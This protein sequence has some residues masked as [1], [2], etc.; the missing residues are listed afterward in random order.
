MNPDYQLLSDRVA[1]ESRVLANTAYER[2]QA[3]LQLEFRGG[4]VYQYFQVPQQI[5]QGLLQADSKGLYF[6]RHIRNAFRCLRIAT[7]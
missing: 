5:H 4:Q 2:D 6:N 3:I 1:V 7:R